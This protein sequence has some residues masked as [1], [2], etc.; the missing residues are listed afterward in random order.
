MKRLLILAAALAVLVP[1]SL[2]AKGSTTR[3]TITDTRGARSI[4][5]V[6]PVVL[7]RFNVWDGPG[8]FSGP[9][10]QQTESVT[11][12]IVDWRTGALASRRSGLDEFEVEFFVRHRPDAPE[13]LAYTVLYA[14]D[15]RSGEGFVYLPGRSDA[16]FPLNTQSIYRGPGYEGQ[17]FRASQ[18][19][20]Q[21]ATQLLRL[22]GE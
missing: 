15:P 22:A 17:W 18:E 20:Q 8:T 21:A 19:W 16:R 7:A 9:P 6:D 3:I 1:A 11:G 14:R 2:V 10:N 13:R 5:V 4:S 12:F